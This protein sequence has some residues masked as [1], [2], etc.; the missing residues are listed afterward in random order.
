MPP[1]SRM[2]TSFIA[3]GSLWLALAFSGCAMT[4][5]ARA[6]ALAQNG[7]WDDAVAMYRLA[8]KDNPYD[9]VLSASLETAKAQ[10]ALVHARRGKAHLQQDLLRE[11]IGEFKTALALDPNN[12]EHQAALA[13]AL[14]LKQARER[15]AMGQKLQAM[16]RIDDALASFERAAELDPDLAEALAGI[17]SAT[18][19]KRMAQALRGSIK[20]I[21]LRFQNAKLREAFEILARTAGLNVIFD[22][23]V[24]DEPIT[25]FIKD[26]SFDEALNL[27]LHTNSLAAQRVSTDTLLIIPN[28]KQKQY[29]DLQIR[30]FYLSNAKAKDAINVL[31]TMLESKRLHVDEKSNT[32]IMRDEPAKIHLAERIIYSI[33]RQ[34]P[35]VALDLEVLEVDRTKSLKYGLNF[36]K[37]AGAGIVPPGFT[38]NFSTN[39]AQF[40]YQQLTSLG[41]QSYLFTF[42]GSVLLD[43]FK[44]ESDAKTL[45]APRLRVLNNKSASIMVGDKQPILLSTTNV[46]PGQAATGAVPTT[47]TVTSIEFKDVGVKL[48]VEPT[49]HMDDE[50][51]LKMKVEVTRLGDQ[52]T[53]QASPEIKQFKFGTRTAETSLMIKD[54][55]TVILG[56]LLQD[57]ERR[58]RV[59]LPWIFESIPFLDKLFASTTEDKVTTEVILSITPHI[60]RRMTPPSP[61]GQVY[62]SGTESNFS[63]SPL[64]T[65]RAF[66]I[67][68]IAPTEPAQSRP[69][70]APVQPKSATPQSQDTLPHTQPGASGPPKVASIKRALA[71]HPKDITATVGQELRVDL[72]IDQPG[73]ELSSPVLLAYDP[74]AI[75]FVRAEPGAAEIGTSVVPGLI[76]MTVRGTPGQAGSTATTLASL[77]FRA[78]APGTSSILL[79]PAGSEGGE[80]LAI[81]PGAGG[82]HVRITGP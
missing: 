36:A 55:E 79:Q 81:L 64:F 11:A 43:L 57:E 76:S 26:M 10:A 53:L 32:I 59:K 46:L 37:S 33:D 2:F 6:D 14:R 69:D 8:L 21:T 23:E 4:H 28:N 82:A 42:P 22:K 78:K 61:E 51:T 63:T 25:I 52:I 47:S 18:E 17:T 15:L 44:Q 13:D 12:Q 56:G 3:V 40:N 7:K 19:Q 72:H 5:A 80:G 24:K 45:A 29:Q 66:S 35:E 31:R 62:W 73:S 74:E 38:G 75:Q 34:D 54:D 27:I 67:S 70:T 49:V 30:T 50:L 71:L 1:M 9:P 60:V 48:T 65:P 77:I 16:G 41:P 58:T 20:P 39:P 68:Q